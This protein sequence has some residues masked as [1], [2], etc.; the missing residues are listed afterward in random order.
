[1]ADHINFTE[2]QVVAFDLRD[3]LQEALG[4]LDRPQPLIVEFG[5]FAP[6]DGVTV[7][8]IWHITNIPGMNTATGQYDQ[9]VR[10]F[11]ASEEICGNRFR[12]V[13]PTIIRQHLADLAAQ[14]NPFWFHQTLNL[15]VFNRLDTK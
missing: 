1:M 10:T 13:P 12:D 7:P 6:H 5:T 9:P 3:R 14:H 2:S 15:A 11:S 8:E 4:H